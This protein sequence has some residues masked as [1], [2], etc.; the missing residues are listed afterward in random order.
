MPKKANNKILYKNLF[1]FWQK[2]TLFVFLPDKIFSLFLWKQFIINFIVTILL[3]VKPTTRIN[4]ISSKYFWILKL[5]QLSR[6]SSYFQKA[7]LTRLAHHQ[8]Q[9]AS[10][11]HK[12][13]WPN[14]EIH[15]PNWNQWDRGNH[16]DWSTRCV[17]I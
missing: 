3:Y 8:H 16:C 10:R 6:K 2:H 11:L 12:I 7:C 9:A 15:K 14:F 17:K 5:N 13:Y 1:I 4:S